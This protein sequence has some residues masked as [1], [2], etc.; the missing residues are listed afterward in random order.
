[1]YDSQQRKGNA[2]E[3]RGNVPESQEEWSWIIACYYLYLRPSRP[4]HQP[5]L[6][7]PLARFRELVLSPILLPRIVVSMHI[8]FVLLG[9]LASEL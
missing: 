2:T 8:N 7:M 3:A 6:G 9:R 4:C 5:A 1:M